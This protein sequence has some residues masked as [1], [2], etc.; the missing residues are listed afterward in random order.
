MNGG[1]HHFGKTFLYARIWKKFC[2]FS[3]HLR[4]PYTFSNLCK[5]IETCLQTTNTVQHA[6][7]K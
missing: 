3:V 7:N 4:S 6:S 1:E 2:D 5:D